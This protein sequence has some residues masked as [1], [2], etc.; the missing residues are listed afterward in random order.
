[1]AKPADKRTALWVLRKLRSAGFEALFAG[2]CVRDM[3]LNVRSIDYDVATNATPQQVKRL[4]RHVLLVGAK[5]GVAMVIHRGRKV[6]VTTFRSDISYSDH[7]RP[8]AV[9]FTSA[10]ED[11]QR[12]DFTINGMFY[13]LLAEEVVDYVGGRA[14]LRRGVIR[15]IGDPNQRFEE[16][17][18]RM[19]R[20]VRFGV[21][22]DF[23]IAPATAS[24]IR[25]HASAIKSISGERI[26][27]EVSKMLAHPSGAEAMCT[28]KK[29]GLAREILP[30][31][32]GP[33]SLWDVAMKRIAS[34]ASKRDPCLAFGAMLAD[35][36][37]AKIRGIIRRWGAS[38]DLRDE[39]C[40]YSRHL[41]D[42][43]SAADLPLCD[44]KRLL[45][46]RHF[47]KLR[48]LWRIEE[49]RLTG[50]QLCARRITQRARSIPKS[51]IAPQPFVTGS[52]LIRMG[53]SESP[54]LG[55]V[56]KQ[57]YDAQLNEQLTSRRQA[58]AMARELV[59]GSRRA[60]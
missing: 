50:R 52:D 1:M 41:G 19:V 21:R 35:L 39:L 23:K 29:L 18:L 49:R 24:A 45:A 12:R 60:K 46:N 6:E 20:A 10:A 26:F 53:L 59:G 36:P 31:L 48:V 27:D 37:E 58:L 15:T 28:L 47:E 40:F 32:F 7:R 16:D 3:L 17:Y 57:L 25:R 33:K 11:A 51:K 56:L 43:R 42:W 44:F 4:F 55:R 34:V 5:F 13:D 38:N 22:F 14:D 8:D 9:R 30:E 2:G 54:S